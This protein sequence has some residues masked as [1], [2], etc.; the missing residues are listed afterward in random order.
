METKGYQ[1]NEPGYWRIVSSLGLAST[2]IF[3]AFY[4][5]QPLIPVFEKE[6]SISV[7][8]SSLTMSLA[9]L[10]LMM[11]LIVLGFFRIGRDGSSLSTFPFFYPFFLF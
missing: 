6:F 8:Y 2:F 10:S 3:A 4:A 11:G 9:T 1:I 7:T 5:F